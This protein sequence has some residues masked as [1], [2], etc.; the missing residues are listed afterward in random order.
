MSIGGLCGGGSCSPT[1]TV[2]PADT[3]RVNTPYH[4]AVPPPHAN[5]PVG[6]FHT[7]GV[8]PPSGSHTGFPISVTL[9]NTVADGPKSTTT[10]CVDD[11]SHM[12]FMSLCSSAKTTGEAA[13]INTL[14]CSRAP[15]LSIRELISPRTVL[16]DESTQMIYDLSSRVLRVGVNVCTAPPRCVSCHQRN[17]VTSVPGTR[18]FSPMTF[19]ASPSGTCGC[20]LVCR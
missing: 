3:R 4:H 5:H 9:R 1:I 6:V 14:N 8:P 15:T 13:T 11:P 20:P 16:S 12:R 10:T 2:L 7:T 19:R 18:Y 17:G